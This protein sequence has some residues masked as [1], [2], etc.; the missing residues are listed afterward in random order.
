MTRPRTEWTWNI[1]YDNISRHWL[2]N[3]G[4]QIGMLCEAEIYQEDVATLISAVPDMLSILKKL[5]KAH[6][7]EG[8]TCDT[9]WELND[10]IAKAEGKLVQCDMCLH[11]TADYYIER[12]D[13]INFCFACAPMPEVKTRTY[14]VI[15]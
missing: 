7:P 6:E 10:V 12:I 15:V 1:E 11:E 2:L 13:D 14:G 4:M 8:C 9:C 5:V 3:I